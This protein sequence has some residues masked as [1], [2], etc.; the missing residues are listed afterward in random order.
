MYINRFLQVCSPLS[1]DS[2]LIKQAVYTIISILTR[3]IYF[4]E[5]NR[6]SFLLDHF[7]RAED[8]CG[9]GIELVDL[10]LR[11]LHASSSPSKKAP[12]WALAMSNRR[13]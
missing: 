6:K 11:V 12:M 1:R 7:Y 4:Y 8:F 3:E 2:L 5:K 9:P 10:H 13:V